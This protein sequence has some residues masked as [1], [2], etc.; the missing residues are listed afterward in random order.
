MS[1]PSTGQDAKFFS[2][3]RRHVVLRCSARSRLR[4]GERTSDDALTPRS[5]LAPPLAARGKIQELRTELQQSDAGLGGGMGKKGDKQFG[6]KKIVLKKI[7]AN[8]RPAS[9]RELPWSPAQLGRLPLPG[10][11]RA[12]LPPCRALCEAQH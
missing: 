6:K 4:R 1:G 11:S 10:P 9:A 7:V 3:C 12:G 5:L 8:V 2:A